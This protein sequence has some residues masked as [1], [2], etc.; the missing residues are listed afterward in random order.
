MPHAE[1]A[2]LAD[3]RLREFGALCVQPGLMNA[4][5]GTR[6]TRSKRLREFGALCV[7]PGLMNVAR[8][9]RGTR[10][11]K[12]PRVRR[13]FTGVVIISA[14]DRAVRDRRAGTIPPAVA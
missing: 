3:K 12:I 13:A 8:G 9:T 1:P 14:S 6:G 2:E 10:K 7:Q 4:A 5:R 11:D